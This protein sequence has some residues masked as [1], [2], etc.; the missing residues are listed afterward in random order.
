MQNSE[1]AIEIVWTLTGVSTTTK[2]SWIEIWGD[3][4]D[5]AMKEGAAVVDNIKS[6]IDTLIEC[7]VGF[8]KF[9]LHSV[10]IAQIVYN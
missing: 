6:K 10:F 9:C 4:A 1:S 7:I 5:V 8:N 3:G 2:D